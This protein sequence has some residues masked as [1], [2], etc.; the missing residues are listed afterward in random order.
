MGDGFWNHPEY[1][2]LKRGFDIAVG[3]SSVIQ[4]CSLPL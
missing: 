1:L 4:V 2:G 3:D